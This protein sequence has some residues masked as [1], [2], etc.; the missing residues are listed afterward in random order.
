MVVPVARG[1]LPSS[2]E[3][4]DARFP[5]SKSEVPI[6]GGVVVILSKDVY[7]VKMQISPKKIISVL[8]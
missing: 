4:T 5:P 7:A 3:D 8:S 1:W 2:E 6:G